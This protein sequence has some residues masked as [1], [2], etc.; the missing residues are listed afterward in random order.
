MKHILKTSFIVIVAA[1]VAGIAFGIYRFNSP[2]PETLSLEPEPSNLVYFKETYEGCRDQ[3]RLQAEKVTGRFDGVEISHLSV[4]SGASSD[5][6][7]DYCY[8]PAQKESRRLM[9]L[10]SGIHGVEGYVGSAVQQMVLNE[11]VQTADLQETGILFVHGLN[12]YGFKFNRRVTENNVDLNRNCMADAAGFQTQNRG[13][14]SLNSWLNQ[15]KPLNL[16]AFD[17]FFFPFYAARKLLKYKTGVMRQAV[18][19][20]QYQYETGI[21]FGGKALEPNIE[22]FTPL[23]QSVAADYE[24]VLAIDLHSGYGERGTLHLFPAVLDHP[25]KRQRIE[26]LFDGF[27]ID[28]ADTE[29]FYTVNGDLL[30]YL[31]QVLSPDIYMSMPFEFG[32][33]D[34][35][36]TLGSIKALH[37][38]MVENQGVH[39]GYA[40]KADEIKVKKRFIE[41]FF[42]SS[43]AWRSKAIQDARVLMGTT[44]ERFHAVSAAP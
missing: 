4:D 1:L 16:T 32:T 18:L 36:S 6:T 39:H 29:D 11:M 42:P 43:P 22:V 33:Q 35:Q 9:I 25:V 44:L 19:Q 13:Y 7:I 23:V 40:D 24:I 28:W 12:P 27:H 41:G 26:A 10:I 3:F 17:H 8:I 5:L 15:R 38:M 30:T 31:G 37:N 14:T 20:G 21:Y 2:M 34:T